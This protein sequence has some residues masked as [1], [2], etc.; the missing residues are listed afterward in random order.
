VVRPPGVGRFD[1]PAWPERE[2]VR[3]DWWWLG[4]AA[5][6]VDGA[7]RS[8]RRHVRRRR[9]IL[10]GRLNTWAAFHSPMATTIEEDRS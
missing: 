7:R 2:P 10:T 1:D 4:A 8:V 3:S 5:L 6:D 9:D